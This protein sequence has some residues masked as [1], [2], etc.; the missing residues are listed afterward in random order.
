M[1]DD[2][3]AQA[4]AEIILLIGGMIIIVLV[5]LYLYRNYLTDLSEDI[6][7]NEVNN[8]NNEILHME[9]YFK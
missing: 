2:E 8:F 1:F 5:A 6:S 4:A 9:E 3:S 7:K